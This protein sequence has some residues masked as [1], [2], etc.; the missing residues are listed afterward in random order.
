MIII[1]KKK[2]VPSLGMKF[3]QVGELCCIN[4]F[5]GVKLTLGQCRADDLESLFYMLMLLLYGE[6]PWKPRHSSAA[7]FI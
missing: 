2:R 1:K 4:V 3:S 6:L 5:F 7:D